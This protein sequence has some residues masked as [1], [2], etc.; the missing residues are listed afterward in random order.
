MSNDYTEL[1]IKR[2]NWIKKIK[3]NQKLPS[4]LHWINK[5]RLN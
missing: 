2:L 3:F 4:D 5:E 1:T